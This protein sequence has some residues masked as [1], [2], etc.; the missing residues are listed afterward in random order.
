[1][2]NNEGNKV[3][4]LANDHRKSPLVG[5]VTD[6]GDEEDNQQGQGCAD[7]RESICGSAVEAKSPTACYQNES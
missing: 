1:M 6:V 4:D 2:G 5:L 3:Q 7:R